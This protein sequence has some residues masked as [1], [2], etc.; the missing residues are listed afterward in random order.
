MVLDLACAPPMRPPGSRGL[1]PRPCVAAPRTVHLHMPVRVFSFRC[2]SFGPALPSLFLSAGIVWVP[3]GGLCARSR[4]G[5]HGSLE[6]GFYVTGPVFF[7]G[8]T[9][10]EQ[11]AKTKTLQ[12]NERTGKHVGKYRITCKNALEHMEIEVARSLSLENV[13]IVF[14]TNLK[15]L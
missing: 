6:P 13:F 8:F 1:H 12:E 4:F 7:E 9:L 15:N 10:F 11:L 14:L 2:V 3:R 5:A